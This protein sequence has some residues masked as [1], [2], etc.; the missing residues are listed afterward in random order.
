MTIEEKSNL[1]SEM[2]QTRFIFDE[3]KYAFATNNGLI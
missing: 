1:R 2:S 3:L